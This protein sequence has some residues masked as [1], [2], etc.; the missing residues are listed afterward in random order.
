MKTDVQADL[1]ISLYDMQTREPL[2]GG[3]FVL[4]RKD[5]ERTED[6][7]GNV[8]STTTT[9]TTLGR[10]T[11]NS[12][13]RITVLYDFLSNATSDPDA[14][15]EEYTLTQIGAPQSYIAVPNTTTFFLFR[16]DPN[17]IRSVDAAVY[18]NET[19]WEDGY[20]SSVLGDELVAYIDVFNKQFS[21]RAK[22]DR[23]CNKPACE[24]SK[25]C[26]FTEA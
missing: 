14:T 20:K 7:E 24:R 26:S 21:L 11:S 10:F 12:F 2:A 22:K 13:G 16:D 5:I 15:V 6:D 19:M 17:N 1:I 18:G 9:T 8:I 25:V 3:E 23:Q 4:K